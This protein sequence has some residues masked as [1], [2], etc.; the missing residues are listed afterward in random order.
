[1]RRAAPTLLVDLGV[2]LERKI[3]CNA[4]LGMLLG[5]DVTLNLR[6][7]L[8]CRQARIGQ[9]QSQLQALAGFKYDTI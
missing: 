1:M 8:A 9:G 5:F 3:A 2:G 7:V 6:S 4:V